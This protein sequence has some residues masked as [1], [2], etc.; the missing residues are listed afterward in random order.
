MQ[1]KKKIQQSAVSTSVLLIAV[2]VLVDTY[3]SPV[4]ALA[5]GE[6]TERVH[7]QQMRGR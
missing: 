6:A 3:T 5:A 4:T 1:N 2:G 7:G